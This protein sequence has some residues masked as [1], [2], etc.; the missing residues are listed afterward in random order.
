MNK[1][2]TT[3]FFA[4]ILLF[5][6]VSIGAHS[7]PQLETKVYFA[8]ETVDLL[9]SR[10]GNNPGLRQGDTISPY[11][12]SMVA[13]LIVH[14]DTREQALALLDQALAQTQV[15]GLSTNVQFLRHDFMICRI[16]A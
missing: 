15:V 10:V 14:G 5:N 8:P 9:M 3:M 7:V 6:P 16:F 1:T 13:K 12:D 2:I 11:Y 4:F